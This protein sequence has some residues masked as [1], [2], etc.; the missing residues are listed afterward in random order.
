[1]NPNSTKH[2]SWSSFE[3]TSKRVSIVWHLH[4]SSSF[5]GIVWSNIFNILPILKFSYTVT[6]FFSGLKCKEKSSSRFIHDYFHS[7]LIFM[8]SNKC[9]SIGL[10]LSFFVLRSNWRQ[11][12]KFSVNISVD[13]LIFTKVAM[14][15]SAMM[16]IYSS[17]LVWFERLL[18]IRSV[19]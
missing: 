13:G 4:Y 3:Y 17:I 14:E 10:C 11:R 9:K 12:F 2:L 18:I 5:E 6:L 1:M 19:Y 8:Q 7:M 16:V 15:S